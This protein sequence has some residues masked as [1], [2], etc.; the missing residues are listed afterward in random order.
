MNYEIYKTKIKNDT[1]IK[2]KSNEK[3]NP[4]INNTN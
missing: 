3:Q 2:V 1:M 4:L